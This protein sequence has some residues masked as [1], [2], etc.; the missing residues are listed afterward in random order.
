MSFLFFLA[1]FELIFRGTETD[2]Y[3]KYS[4]TNTYFDKVTACAWIRTPDIEKNQIMTIISM[5]TR[6]GGDKKAIKEQIDG[7]GGFYFS[8]GGD[9]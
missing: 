4:M 7:Q 2:T 3:L 9:R 5:V 1:D 8:F 6:D